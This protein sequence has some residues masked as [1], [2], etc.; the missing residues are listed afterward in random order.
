MAHDYNSYDM[1]K[2]AEGEAAVFIVIF[3]SVVSL[4]PV[5]TVAGLIALVRWWM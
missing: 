3:L 2:S 4:I 1:D 5:L